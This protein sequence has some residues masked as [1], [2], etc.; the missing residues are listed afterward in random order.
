MLEKLNLTYPAIICL[1]GAGGKT[2]IM[3]ELARDGVR[4]GLKVL[5][6][7]T[8]HI[9][10]PAYGMGRWNEEKLG[11]PVVWAR[12]EAEIDW[13]QECVYVLGDED[14]KDNRKLVEKADTDYSHLKDIADL[15]LIEADGAKG[16]P[17]KVPRESEPVIVP[18]CDLVLGVIGL[19]ALGKNVS[20]ACFRAELLQ[21]SFALNT[22]INPDETETITPELIANIIVSEYG[23]AKGTNGRRY[24]VVL[25]QADTDEQLRKVSDIVR[26]MGLLKMKAAKYE[27]KDSSVKKMLFPE[28]VI[29]ARNSRGEE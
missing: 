17:L 28:N 16:Y 3:Y 8:T 29:V 10:K 7:T 15:I 23:L 1:T 4:A 18:E 27:G 5:V 11:M 24:I 14:E 12:D 6:M 25:N 2:S 13:A 21:D 22:D 9:W 19:S 26:E 20:E